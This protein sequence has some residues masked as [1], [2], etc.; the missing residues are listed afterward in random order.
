MIDCGGRVGRD[1]APERPNENVNVFEAAVAHIKELRAAGKAVI[2]A[3]WSDGSR[4]RLTHVF[5][6][7]GLKPHELVSSYPQ[8]KSARAGALPLAVVAQ[9]RKFRRGDTAT[10]TAATAGSRRQPRRCCP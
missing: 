2:V 5:A 7:H 4:E 6:D 8:A 1:F 10:R 9:F 3:G